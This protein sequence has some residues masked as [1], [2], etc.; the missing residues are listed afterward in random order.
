MIIETKSPS[1]NGNF[2]NPI[3][4]VGGASVNKIMHRGKEMLPYLI[5]LFFASILSI[6]PILERLF[7]HYHMHTLMFMHL[8]YNMHKCM[9][10]ESW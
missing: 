7:V 5:I 2:I 9:E 4:N 6:I 10:G 3:I 8:F 1:V